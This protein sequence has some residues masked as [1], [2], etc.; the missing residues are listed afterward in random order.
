MHTIEIPEAKKIVYIPEDLSECDQIQYINISKLLFQLN[1]GVIT[2]IDFLIHAA[3]F[4]A[5]GKDVDITENHPV[6]F[7]NIYQIASVLE[8]FFEMNDDDQFVI[9]QYFI[10]NPIPKVT[11]NLFPYYGPTD[12]FNNVTFGEYVDG[13]SYLHDFIETQ[14]TK[15]LYLLFATF[16]RRKKRAF[17]NQNALLKDVRQEY[18]PEKVD[19]LANKFKYLDIG[20]IYGFFLLF[21]SFQ[22]YMT[23]AKIYVQGNE[24]DF[25]ILYNDFSTDIKFD[26]TIPGIG[27]KSLMYSI[28]ESGVFGNL[29]DVRNASFWE[30]M[31][32]FYDVRKRDLDAITIQKNQANAKS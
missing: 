20:I 29:D 17:F 24:I 31:I 19:F 12:E 10:H 5:L 13:V 25:S 11:P 15:Y 16:Y 14:E 7:S 26:S 21:T 3:K 23:T 6:K 28:A 1:I 8:S 30:I 22:K 18:L 4:L 32:R 2:R 9:K 27:M